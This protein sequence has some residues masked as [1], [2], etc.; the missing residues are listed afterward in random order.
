MILTGTITRDRG[1]IRSNSNEGVF[2]TPQI[3]RTGVLPSNAV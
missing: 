3:S 1:G 2:D